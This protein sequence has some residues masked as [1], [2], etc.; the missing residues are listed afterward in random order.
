M[1]RRFFTALSVLAFALTASTA[2]TA[3][4]QHPRG[5]SIPQVA[6]TAGQFTTLLAAVEAAGLGEFLSG[7]GPITVFAP[8]DEA[9]RRL[10]NGTVSDLLKPENR[11]QLRTL[12]SYHVVAGRVTAAEAR[13]LS[14][15]KTVA[16][17]DVRIRTSDGELRINDAV[18]RIADIPASNGLVHVIDRV[19]M[20]TPQPC[21]TE[22]RRGW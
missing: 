18:V 16:N 7:R 6:K 13:Q 1:S 14:S 21:N 15:A 8:T 4:A 2:T 12:L 17:Q 3:Q 11:E 22:S 19:L 20:P 5:P 10:P 9:F